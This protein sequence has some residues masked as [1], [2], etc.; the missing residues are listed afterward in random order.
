[1]LQAYGIRG[2]AYTLMQ[3]Y[4]T[5]GKQKVRIDQRESE[6]TKRIYE[7]L[8]KSKTIIVAFLDLAKAF[9]TVDHNILLHKLQ[10]YGMPIN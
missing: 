7:N 9:D 10:A 1:M 6:P 5:N 2:N 4:L 3:S 8:D